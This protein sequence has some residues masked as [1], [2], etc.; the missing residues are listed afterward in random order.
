MTLLRAMS[1]QYSSDEAILQAF[2]ETE[3]IDRP[4]PRRPPSSRAGSPAATSSTRH[5]RGPDRQRRHISKAS[6]QVLA[7]AGNLGRS[8]S[9]RMP[10]TR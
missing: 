7:D 9:S 10:A 3:E 2:Y 6:A 8:R 1:P 4:T 5:R